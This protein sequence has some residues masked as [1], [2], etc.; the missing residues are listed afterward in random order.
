MTHVERNGHHYVDGFGTAPE[1]EAEAFLN[2]HPGLYQRQN[3]RVRLRIA[4]GLIDTHSLQT[5]GFAHPDTAQ[6]DWDSMET[7]S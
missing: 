4:D 1:A 2:A 7:F 5:V 3:Q 6:P